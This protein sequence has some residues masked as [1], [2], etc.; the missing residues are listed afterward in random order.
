[1]TRYVS[2]LYYFYLFG[3]SNDYLKYENPISLGSV[4]LTSV[5]LICLLEF[6]LEISRSHIGNIPRKILTQSLRR[7]NL[8]LSG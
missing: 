2:R 1:M 4:V 6:F 3:V 5:L 7:P 8:H